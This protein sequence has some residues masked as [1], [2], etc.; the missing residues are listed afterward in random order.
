MTLDEELKILRAQNLLKGLSDSDLISIH[1]LFIKKEFQSNEVILYEGDHT[2]D[3]YLIIIGEVTILKWDQDHLLQLP[4]YTLSK[5]ECFGEMSFMDLSPRSSTIKTTKKTTVWQLT[6]ADLDRLLPEKAELQEKIITNIALIN[7]DRLRQ[8]NKQ[9]IKNLR[10]EVGFLQKQ[11]DTGRFSLGLLFLFSLVLLGAIPLLSH[12]PVLYLDFVAWFILFLLILPFIRSY[13][14]HLPGSRKI[15][16][17]ALLESI[18]IALGGILC[19]QLGFW[20]L[21]KFN[22]SVHAK[23]EVPLALWLPLYVL[24]AWVKEY[25]SRGVLQNSL[26]IFFNEDKKIPIFLTATWLAL[27]QIPFFYSLALLEFMAGILIGF[28]YLRRRSLLEVVILH[29]IW[30]IYLRFLGLNYNL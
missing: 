6:R 12:L 18:G 8:S 29:F 15:G 30:G 20:L 13:K 1:Q 27:F 11:I 24:Y 7:I 28:A 10:F 22:F 25:I 16:K 9:Q 17:E 19:L 23:P 3:L 5:G 21:L 26:E 4:L 14:F 2:S